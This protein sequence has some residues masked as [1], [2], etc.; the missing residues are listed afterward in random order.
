MFSCCKRLHGYSIEVY[1]PKADKLIKPKQT[2]FTYHTKQELDKFPTK[3]ER[4]TG[5]NKNENL[6]EVYNVEY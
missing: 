2:R 3:Q 5:T 1:V 4:K 6:N